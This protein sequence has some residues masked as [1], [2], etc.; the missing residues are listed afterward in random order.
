M[1]AAPPI[2]GQ[3]TYPEGV[4]VARPAPPGPAVIFVADALGNRIRVVTLGVSL[5]TLA[6]SGS[7]AY[8]DG[9]GTSASFNNPRALACQACS[10]VGVIRAMCGL[11]AAI[12]HATRA[13]VIASPLAECAVSCLTP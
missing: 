13:A 11:R 1:D 7:A 6:G 5:T 9:A 10:S 2:A 4:C 3:L 8:A 12:R